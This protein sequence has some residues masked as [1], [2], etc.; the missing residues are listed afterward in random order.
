MF[1]MQ[2]H[3][4]LFSQS[5]NIASFCES[6]NVLNIRTVQTITEGEH[7]SVFK[8]IVEHLGLLQFPQCLPPRSHAACLS[9]A[10]C[11]VLNSS[12]QF[13]ESQQL[14][15]TVCPICSIAQHL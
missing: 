9:C 15:D 1:G 7:S 12:A 6:G 5:I 3:T 14:D 8:S 2:F 10:V 13:I 11:S 4:H